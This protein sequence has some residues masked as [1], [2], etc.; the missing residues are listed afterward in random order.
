MRLFADDCLLYSHIRSQATVASVQND[1]DNLKL[2]K[3][4]CLMSFN[5][6]KCEVLRVTNKRTRVIQ[7][8]Y[9]I[10]RSMLRNVDSAK[11]VG[12]MI[13]KS[14]SWKVNIINEKS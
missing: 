2:W 4:K 14:I 12:I 11:Y 9:C 10:H 5:P 8:N 1:I 6:D 13:A 7:Y 3:N